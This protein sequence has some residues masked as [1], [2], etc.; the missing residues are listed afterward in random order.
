MSP[1]SPVTVPRPEG[2]DEPLRTAPLAEYGCEVALIPDDYG[3]CHVLQRPMSARG[4]PKTGKWVHVV[5]PGPDEDTEQK[6]LEAALDALGVE[7]PIR[8]PEGSA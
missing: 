1:A 3:R 6:A 7:L 4:H 2:M 5:E 8:E